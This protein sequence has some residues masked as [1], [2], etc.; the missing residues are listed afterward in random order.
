VCGPGGGNADV[1]GGGDRVA[2]GVDH[3][4]GVG[5]ERERSCRSPG[6]RP[7]KPTSPTSTVDE[8]LLPPDGLSSSMTGTSGA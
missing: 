8:P 1:D 5:V 7:L 6:S 2:G 4:D 3:R